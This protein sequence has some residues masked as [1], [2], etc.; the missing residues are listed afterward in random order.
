MCSGEP[1]NFTAKGSN[2]H[3]KWQPKDRQAQFKQHTGEGSQGYI[4]VHTGESWALRCE[5]IWDWGTKIRGGDTGIFYLSLLPETPS[6]LSIFSLSFSAGKLP[7][8]LHTIY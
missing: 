2:V 5:D 8:F 4:H 6:L 3:V 7:N 1:F